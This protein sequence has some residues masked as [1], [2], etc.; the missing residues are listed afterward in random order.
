[1]TMTMCFNEPGACSGYLRP[2]RRTIAVDRDWQHRVCPR[3]GNPLHDGQCVAQLQLS[4][5]ICLKA[6]RAPAAKVHV[7]RGRSP[8]RSTQPR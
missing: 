5:A 8:I 1:M 3:A 2:A 6:A 7:D 4:V